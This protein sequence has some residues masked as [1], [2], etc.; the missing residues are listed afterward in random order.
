MEMK[1]KPIIVFTSSNTPN[2]DAKVCASNA[3][4]PDMSEDDKK[5]LEQFD[6]GKGIKNIALSK[7]PWLSEQ[8]SATI[9][10]FQAYKMSGNILRTKHFEYKPDYYCTPKISMFDSSLI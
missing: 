3:K 5:L 1:S 7:K 8:F 6:G 2:W 10:M 9:P 4:K